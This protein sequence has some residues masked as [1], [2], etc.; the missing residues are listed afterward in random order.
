M[1][2][3]SS[4]R[5]GLPRTARVRLGACAGAA[6]GLAL[7][8]A[9]ATP[10]ALGESAWAAG[11]SLS[12]DLPLD[13]TPGESCW[14]SK[15]VD[16]DPGPGV[17]DFMCNGRVSDDHNG[18]DIALRDQN[19]ME[20]GVRV[21]AAAPGVVRGTR[22]G[23][24][25][26]NVRT[27]GRD[28]LNGKDCGN[29][30]AIRHGEGWETQYC[31]LKRGSVQVRRGDR[32]ERGQPLGL[33]GLSGNTEYPHLHISVRHDGE[34]VDP[35]LGLEGRAAE[36]ARCGLGE[37][38]LW[39]PAALQ[40]LAYTPAAIYNVGF[41]PVPP[42]SEDV[43]SGRLRATRLSS[44]APTLIL[45]AEIFGIEAGDEL[46]LRLVAPDGTPLVD[47]TKTLQERK[48]RWFQYVGRKRR[49]E[50]WPTGVYRAEVSLAR[51][52]DGT[53]VVTSVT[54]ELLVTENGRGS[55]PAIAGV[56]PASR[57]QPPSQA[58]EQSGAITPKRVGNGSGFVVNTAGHVLTNSHV[59]E[60]CR[61]ITAILND[62]KIKASLVKVDPENGLA[63]L[64]LSAPPE[65][66]AIFRDGPDIR[67]GETV[68]AI[69]FPLQEILASELNVTTGTLSAPAGIRNDVR[70]LQISAPVQPGNSGGPLLDTSGNVIGVVT[71]RLNALAVGVATGHIPQNVNFAIN[72]S[73]ARIFL[74]ANGVEYFR[75]RSSVKSETADIAEKARKYT[76]LLE[77]WN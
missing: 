25:D 8:I 65:S 42:E 51:D 72:G 74:E 12:L 30:V 11:A 66:A 26:V 18:V 70:F 41:S 7:G 61:E 49:A 23:M 24:K 40:A 53:K 14:I 73:V 58:P 77:C 10:L 17:R 27:V 13:C 36:G 6:L 35:F 1:R 63:L 16:L 22:D 76:V 33:V 44:D 59:V 21:L 34:V 56:P 67:P 45:W 3:S 39:S 38:P 75:T 4:V 57:A 5:T 32:V 69:G 9:F 31:H 46:R 64:R 60:E 37:A 48:A 43:R 28:S 68:V 2:N 20:E 29:G 19:A 47:H 71:S 54:R 15:F 62:K 52:M 55:E 50:A